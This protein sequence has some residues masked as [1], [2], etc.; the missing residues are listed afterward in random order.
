MPWRLTVEMI[1]HP[2]WA[3]HRLLSPTYDDLHYACVGIAQYLKNNLRPINLILGLSRG[4]LIPAVIISHILEVPMIP[5]SYSSKKG[6]GDDKNHQN[7]LPELND[8]SILILDDIIDSGHT[9]KEVDTYYSLRSG[10]NVYTASLY[11]KERTPIVYTPT[12]HWI[13]IPEDSNWVIF[14]WEKR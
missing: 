6:M 10:N 1:S 12:V 5:V 4:G 11:Y 14:P 9:M 3:K 7:T 13:T 8:K 2:Q